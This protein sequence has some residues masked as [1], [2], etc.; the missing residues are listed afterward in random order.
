MI[1]FTLNTDYD[2]DL[3]D[4]KNA[5]QEALKKAINSNSAKIKKWLSDASYSIMQGLIDPSSDKA[6]IKISNKTIGKIKPNLPLYKTDFAKYVLSK[7]GAGEL[8]LPDPKMAMKDLEFALLDSFSVGANVKGVDFNIEFNLNLNNVLNKTPHPGKS[9]PN[10][11]KIGLESWLQWTTG[12]KFDN[13][14]PDFGLAR[15]SDLKNKKI[16]PRTLLYSGNEAGVMLSIISTPGKRS[17]YESLTG[18]IGSSWKP[19]QNFK[20]KYWENWLLANSSA[21]QDIAYDIFKAILE[22]VLK[23]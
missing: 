12:P 16:S 9:F 13:G 17:P 1:E 14:S 11:K 4:L 5:F 21:I 6:N 8:G 19:V 3:G 7:A 10:G 22:E 20:N 15:L 18:E 23:D 2:L